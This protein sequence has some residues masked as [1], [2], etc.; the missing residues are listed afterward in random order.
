VL[1]RWLSTELFPTQYDP[2]ER[3]D[4][5][6]PLLRRELGT[7]M[8]TLPH[9]RLTNYDESF[10]RI[11]VVIHTLSCC[12]CCWASMTPNP[13]LPLLA[14]IVPSL[15]IS[16][17]AD[18]YGNVR[19]VF[20]WHAASQRESWDILRLA[21]RD[22]D[23]L[24]HTYEAIGNLRSWTAFRIDMTMRAIPAAIG[25]V[26]GA[27]VIIGAAVS[28]LSLLFDT[29][30]PIYVL[31]S[32]GLIVYGF[33]LVRVAILYISD[34]MWRF[35]ANTMWSLLCAMRF[36]DTATAIASAIM[37]SLSVR[38]LHLGGIV[39][40]WQLSDRVL[41]GRS[42]FEVQPD[43]LPFIVWFCVLGLLLPI[44]SWLYMRLYTW[45][46]YCV[47]DTLRSGDV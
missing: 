7:A 15:L 33:L 31:Q 39:A 45:L 10:M 18:C 21:M 44:T 23:E 5:I 37:G 28:L 25:V 43:Y 35:R 30:N 13:V 29:R 46:E 16:I 19:T 8:T 32:I 12:A 40:L 38:L 42:V 26:A 41:D 9:P 20:Q 2:F 11:A 3:L 17:G 27:A 6:N 4:R 34:P 1:S 36:R 24:V 14:L 22:D 47:I